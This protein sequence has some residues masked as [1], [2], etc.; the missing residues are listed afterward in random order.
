[1]ANPGKLA[2]GTLAAIVGPIVAAA[3]LV[4][5]PAEESGRK[6]AVTIAADGRATVRH[7][8][9][10]QYLQA[11]LDVIGVATACDGITGPEI[12]RARRQG[13][14]FTEAECAA[15]LEAAL[16]EHSKIV[17]GCTPGLALSSDPGLER[18]REGPRFAAVA[19]NYNHG[20]V[21]TSTARIR[22]NRGDYAGGCEA[23]TWYRKAGGKVWPGLVS[24]RQR[25]WVKCV[26]GLR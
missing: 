3:L 7:V 10:R 22:F 6:V 9:G 25:E 14:K 15:M 16:V 2:A 26:G 11:Y 17:M 18:R 8:S 12:D 20:R 24:R 1:M 4:E 5:T 21:C 13:R 19:G 23:L